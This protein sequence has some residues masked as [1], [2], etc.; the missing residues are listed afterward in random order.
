MQS[1]VAQL[2][3]EYYLEEDEYQA[4]EESIVS[5]GASFRADDQFMRDS[6]ALTLLPE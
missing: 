5:V 6:M 3:T 1:F 2:G 4:I